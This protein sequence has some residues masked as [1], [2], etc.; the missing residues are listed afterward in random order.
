MGRGAFKML[1]RIIPFFV[2]QILLAA[3]GVTAT[4]AFNKIIT[5]ALLIP[6]DIKLGGV[7]RFLKL[8][9]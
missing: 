2:P 7:K 4:R 8:W 5:P 6:K 9:I 3:V 1:W